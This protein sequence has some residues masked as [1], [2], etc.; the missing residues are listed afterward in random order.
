MRWR[1]SSSEQVRSRTATKRGKREERYH[2]VCFKATWQIQSTGT[3]VESGRAEIE[4]KSYHLSSQLC[5]GGVDEVVLRVTHLIS[6]RAK[7]GLEGSWG[8]RFCRGSGDEGRRWCCRTWAETQ[9]PLRS[10]SVVIA[11]GLMVAKKE[12]RLYLTRYIYMPAVVCL[13]VMLQ[14]IPIECTWLGKD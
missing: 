6:R 5:P 8:R 10:A 13:S 4:W 14:A 11:D 7:A 1:R 9:N 3:E 2:S 12:I